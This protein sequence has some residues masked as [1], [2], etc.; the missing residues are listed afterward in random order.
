MG[1]PLLG[2]GKRWIRLRHGKV[3]ALGTNRKGRASGDG[4][5]PKTPFA[6]PKGTSES[7]VELQ[8]LRR[9]EHRQHLSLALMRQVWRLLNQKN[10]AFRPCSPE[11]NDIGDGVRMAKEDGGS[12]LNG[13]SSS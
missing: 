9:A 4:R 7:P 12:D 10:R 2:Q 1:A 3:P 8:S 13:T 11:E 5:P 6:A